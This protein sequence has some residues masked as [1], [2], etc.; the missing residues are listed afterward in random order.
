MNRLVYTSVGGRLTKW[1]GKVVS[2]APHVSSS[3]AMG[4]LASAI[5]FADGAS[6]Q[7]AYTQG[8]TPPLTL[9]SYESA[10]GGFQQNGT[11]SMIE[12]MITSGAV[13]STSSGTA[14][15][16][17][18]LSNKITATAVGNLYDNSLDIVTLT[19]TG[20]GSNGVIAA[21]M[22]SAANDIFASVA[23][24]NITQTLSGAMTGSAADVSNNTISAS[25]NLA[26]STNILSGALS[27]TF[28]NTDAGAVTVTGAAISAGAVASATAGLVLQSTQL[29]D[30]VQ[31]ATA[32]VVAATT[33]SSVATSDVKLT[34]SNTAGT[35]LLSLD[36]NAI[37]AD[38]QGNTAKN[39]LSVETGGMQTL[40]SDAGIS[41]LQI[42]D[43]VG[44]TAATSK[45]NNAVVAGTSGVL[46]DV[47]GALT[48]TSVELTNNTIA[49]TSAQNTVGN[50]LYLAD[51]ISRIGDT[52]TGIAAASLTAAAT[53]AATVSA[54][55]FVS[56]V[57]GS[58]DS[59]IRSINGTSGAASEGIKLSSTGAAT[60]VS[61]DLSLND[62]TASA[63]G[64]KN[65][66]NLYVD[67]ANTLNAIV[68]QTNVQSFK[69]GTADALSTDAAALIYDPLVTA[70]VGTNA[71]V[72]LDNTSVS[73]ASNTIDAAATAN[74]ATMV[75]S[76][77]GN[78]L[79]DA[80]AAVALA[81][82]ATSSTNTSTGVVS[83]IAGYSSV[84]D[85]TVV[86]DA[87]AGSTAV[88]TSAISDT[89]TGSPLLI[90]AGNATG[91]V[92]DTFFDLANNTISS[93]AKANTA[94]QTL[95]IDANDLQASSAVIG[96]QTLKG[97]VSAALTGTS[98]GIAVAAGSG[99][100]SN[101]TLNAEQ[102]ATIANASGNTATNAM[103]VTANVLT[104][105]NTVVAA[106]ATDRTSLSLDG[107]GDASSVSSE[108]AM[109]NMQKS[110]VALASDTIS[111][112][113]S[114]AGIN[115]TLNA[116]GTTAVSN[117][118]ISVDSNAI[119]GTARANTATNTMS[120]D[121]G[122]M[123]LT[124]AVWDT[125][126]TAVAAAGGT[127]IAS[128]GSSQSNAIDVTTSLDSAGTGATDLVAKIATSTGAVNGG[129]TLSVS[130]N[131]LTTLAAGNS[132]T[133]TFSLIGSAVSTPESQNILPTLTLT[134][135]DT[136]AGNLLA[137]N[138][139]FAVGNDQ[140]NYGVIS[141]S[142]GT[143]AG[144]GET[145][146]QA[147]AAA[148]TAISNSSMAVDGNRVIA[149]AIAASD[150][151][152]S[153]TLDATSI[154]TSFLTGSRQLNTGSVTAT[155]G[156]ALAAALSTV[157][158]QAITDT[159]STSTVTNMA[160]S[161][162]DNTIGASATAL[163]DSSR[164]LIG[165]SSTTTVA[166][167]GNVNA[168]E[169]V[170]S[171]AIASTGT[172][173]S[174][175]NTTTNSA[176][177]DFALILGQT[178]A[179]A[180]TAKAES[181]NIDQTLGAVSGGS[182]LENNRNLVT[183]IATAASGANTID[184]KASGSNTASTAL[185]ATQTNGGAVISTV[186]APSLTTGLASIA[187]SAAEIGQ[188][189]VAA[190]ATGLTDTNSLSVTGGSLASIPAGTPLVPSTVVNGALWVPATSTITPFN[191]TGS[192]ATLG[193]TQYQNAAVTATIGDSDLTTT[194]GAG[195]QPKILL[196]ITGATSGSDL[197][198]T[199][200]NFAASATVGTVSNNLSLLSDTSINAADTFGGANLV[201]VQ[202]GGTG[203]NALAS[204]QGVN[205]Q[206]TGTTATNS[207]LGITGNDANALATGLTAFNTSA[208]SA[209]TS[210]TGDAGGGGVGVAS[211]IL[212]VTETTS[213]LANTQSNVGT[214]KAELL[215][216]A[217]TA[218]KMNVVLSGAITAS[219]VDISDNTMRAQ[220]NGVTA[221]NVSSLSA[222][223][224]TDMGA[225]VSNDQSQTTG[226]VG[227]YLGGPEML[228]SS[229]GS[230]T[231]TLSTDTNIAVAS[232]TATSAVNRLTANADTS[233]D[234][235]AGALA[236]STLT[237][238][239]AAFSTTYAT[240]LLNRQ[241]SDAA[242]TSTIGTA[243]VAGE[244]KIGTTV[245]GLF[246]GSITADSNTI[247][248]QSLGNT[249]DSALSMNA[250]TS[251]SAD[252][253]AVLASLQTQ[254]TGAIGATVSGST[255]A[256][257]QVTSTG[258]T[259]AASA[260]DN[261]IRASSSANTTQND[262]SITSA[263][264][265]GG[266]QTSDASSGMT[267]V[268]VMTSKAQYAALISQTNSSAVTAEVAKYQIG[269]DTANSTTNATSG[270]LSLNGNTVMA[271]GTASS[272]VN[273]VESVTSGANSGATS[274]L[275]FQSNTA[276]GDVTSTITNA[277]LK[278]NVGTL[279]AGSS[280]EMT[281][282]RLTAAATGLTNTNTLT[283][284]GSEIAQVTGGTPVGNVNLI[285]AALTVADTSS[286]L[287]NSQSNAG[288]AIATVDSSAGSS[289]LANVVGTTITSSAIDI[290][291]NAI[292]AQSN[293]VTAQN[294][295]NLSGGLMTD[296]TAGVTNYQEQT[297]A[298]TA[299]L[300][301]P[302]MVI[303]AAAN[304]TGSGTLSTDGNLAVASATAANA[305]NRLSVT[306]DTSVD[307]TGAT[308][309][310][311][312][313]ITM[314]SSTLDS[315]TALTLLNSQTGSA[316][317]TS[318]INNDAAIGT[319][320]AGTFTGS[321]TAD[322]NLIVSQSRGNVADSGLVINA[323]TSVSNSTQ[324][325]VASS[326]DRT[327]GAISATVS[328][329]ALGGIQVTTGTAGTAGLT[330]TASVSDNTIRASGSANT[331]LNAMSVV[332]AAGVD[333]VSTA[334]AGSSI[335]SAG[336][337]SSTAQYA[338]L[339]GQNNASAVNAT[340]TDYQIGL[341]TSAGTNSGSLSLNG[342]MMMADATGNNAVNNLM[343]TAGGA[344]T[345]A[346]GSI[347]NYQSNTAAMIANVSN[348]G[349]VI[350]AG[351][352]TGS[353]SVANNAISASAMGNSATSVIGTAGST[354]QSY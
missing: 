265:I 17:D 199:S 246:T 215:T 148:T 185:I 252:T 30:D 238:N 217:P 259:G 72:A 43:N 86:Q 27:T 137:E 338:V 239:S 32:N 190:T 76:L 104:P 250:G 140:F 21:A 236:L 24:S 204:I 316:V 168:N 161:T 4:A 312:K 100:V 89:V 87:T 88:V 61:L 45:L 344:G 223:L 39:T 114:D 242:V 334:G 336:T 184:S 354:F 319:T 285:G 9:S 144:A 327:A 29:N 203:A 208:L 245:T 348:V 220:A 150:A 313:A 101:V 155:V 91:A 197:A 346:S 92:T 228:I 277:A 298:T 127:N 189:T 36:S 352:T 102:N 322:K 171:S 20:A 288:D 230:G 333:A 218:P 232:S 226:A 311:S 214:V 41:N 237:T 22:E 63:T 146:L 260:S 152:T 116:A 174:T 330:G 175:G 70:V 341:N 202:N 249:S 209:G 95:I 8:A 299:T 13:T 48:T 224:M 14:T 106:V 79:T 271:D 233:I 57:Q 131:A 247:L 318:L 73:V 314:A 216:T 163:A 110:S 97:S 134:S 25:V 225:A 93:S 90:T 291:N 332:G 34:V 234:G 157:K 207:T 75:T 5:L 321:I 278:T 264:G 169:T 7:V 258:L 324:A 213:V 11:G 244:T 353:V 187:S 42:A 290:S 129:T 301:T 139:A 40:S 229:V 132:V 46:A 235:V 3:I 83:A 293:G 350:A 62:V 173:V 68:A 326:Q 135:V 124:E 192:F 170:A 243:A 159:T 257:I 55:L 196:A 96:L 49:A 1:K 286:V 268:G 315:P 295:A 56:N 276:A 35:S 74:T 300:D 240:T 287:A 84:S 130:S 153:A 262:L 198:V 65:T 267:S 67:G 51:G 107:I 349:V 303:T 182:V 296:V 69:D 340:L 54:D 273:T 109:L 38:F 23:T 58:V 248:A 292:R 117:A 26:R 222:G 15:S 44:V 269:I 345:D 133:N 105:I 167:G 112:T 227:A 211:D 123:N 317:V 147:S 99:T 103:S 136:T 94:G 138:T 98:S 156:D 253:Q 272:G 200:N 166:G 193:S 66:G 80:P 177:A 119:A 141:S 256:S 297:G 195:T 113:I 50:T 186:T 280:V 210:L 160:V 128:L 126:G 165:G 255:L 325:V 154:A 283:V 183:S 179:G 28:A 289:I 329:A 164:V 145:L 275:A 191:V 270:S 284:S 328:G 172:S 180:V 6:A 309:L 108:L 111:A 212:T 12:A 181:V 263:T 52:S 347:S 266:K 78:S 307:G 331:A 178:N 143:G 282:N 81:V 64:N 337:I 60:G 241:S 205:V 77:K 120:L 305:V 10:S 71:G 125:T 281:M 339:N 122:S 19:G 37:T 323:G 201:S 31:N 85:Q 261:T 47:S 188:N 115:S 251:V 33:F 351:A 18:T 279:S 254:S 53:T 221:Q 16:F 82:A 151:T 158:I 320:I 149:Q 231:G 302:K 308:T 121:I 142:I 294:I 194:T 206:I 335:T 219:S 59:A 274:L 343:L 310:T 2:F 162:S 306:S 342:N 118:R 176:V 304:V